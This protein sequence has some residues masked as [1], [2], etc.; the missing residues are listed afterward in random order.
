M[1]IKDQHQQITIGQQHLLVM[2]SLSTTYANIE[3]G[4]Y[5]TKFHK[6]QKGYATKD[7]D[8]IK[9]IPVSA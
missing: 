8:C 6:T 2:L 4:L 9:K 7:I 3:N 1:V 5:N